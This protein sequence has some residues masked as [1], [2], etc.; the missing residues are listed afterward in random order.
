MNINISTEIVKSVTNKTKDPW[1]LA[2]GDHL[3]LLAP[4]AIDPVDMLSSIDIKDVTESVA[5]ILMILIKKLADEL[6]LPFLRVLRVVLE[7]L[8]GDK[9]P[10]VIIWIENFVRSVVEVIF[11][12]L[13][14]GQ[15][16]SKVEMWTASLTEDLLKALLGIAKEL[17]LDNTL[18]DPSLNSN[19]AVLS[20]KEVSYILLIPLITSKSKYEDSVEDSVDDSLK[21]TIEDFKAHIEKALR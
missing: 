12:A 8:L 13:F 9:S 6:L 15:E 5:E 11:K 14:V 20:A 18:A 2:E 16:S 19:A 10:L 4:V 1:N 3:G 21:A 7:S 17:D